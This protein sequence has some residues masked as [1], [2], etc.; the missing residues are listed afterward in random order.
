MTLVYNPSP[1]RMTIAK[2]LIE[3]MDFGPG[4]KAEAVNLMGRVGPRVGGTWQLIER[5]PLRSLV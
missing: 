1:E 5:F 4:I 2:E 3:A